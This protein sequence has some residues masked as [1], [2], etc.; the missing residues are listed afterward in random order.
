MIDYIACS[1][2]YIQKSTG[3]SLKEAYRH[4]HSKTAHSFHVSQLLW[5]ICETPT[6][7][8][9][10]WQL[11]KTV[12]YRILSKRLHKSRKMSQSSSLWNTPH[13]CIPLEKCMFN[14]KKPEKCHWQLPALIKFVAGWSEL[15][16]FKS[17]QEA[18]SIYWL[19]DYWKSLTEIQM[20]C[21]WSFLCFHIYKYNILWTVCY[22]K[23][24]HIFSS[25]F[26]F[27]KQQT[28]YKTFQFCS[29]A[30]NS[31]L[32]YNKQQARKHLFYF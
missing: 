19:G 25:I 2:L 27:Q 21:W 15:T 7:S 10:N 5:F 24:I 17:S 1:F 22:A 30:W 29:S 8:S 28:S 31:R 32:P 18:R 3:V 16:K 9:C 26:F 6:V 20:I 23:Q 4:E 13:S 14:Y 12:D 11:M